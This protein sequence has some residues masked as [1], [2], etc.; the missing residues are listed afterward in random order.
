MNLDDE[1]EEEE[2]DEQ[3]QEMP[4]PPPQ[5]RARRGGRG[6]GKPPQPPKS[7]ERTLTSIIMTKHYKKVRDPNDLTAFNVRCDNVY[8]L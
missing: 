2:E 5:P 6:R 7:T 4:P 3:R 8:I 1:E